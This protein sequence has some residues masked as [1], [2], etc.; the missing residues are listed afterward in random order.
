MA[1]FSAP[2]SANTSRVPCGSSSGSGIRGGGGGIDDRR[3]QIG[4]RFAGDFRVAVDDHVGEVREQTGGTVLA[5]GKLKQARRLVEEPRRHGAGQE[6]RVL[7]EVQQE[8]HVRLHAADAELLQRPVHPPGRVDEPDAVGRHLHEQR[9]VKR[10]DDRPAERAAV[11]PDAE[12]AG[13]AVRGEPA[14]I[15]GE[16]VGR[17]FR[18]H[19][20]LYRV[21]VGA[22]RGLVA[23]ADFRVAERRALRDE[24]LRLDEVVP[25]DD[26]RDRVFD[27]NPRVDLDEI[28]RAG[29]DIDEEL[30][31]AGVVDPGGA[32][33]FEG[34]FQNAVA[35]LRVEVRRRGEFDDLLVPPLNGTVAVEQVDEA[36]VPVAEQLHLDVLGPLD[37]LFEEHAAVAERTAGLAAGRF[38]RLGQFRRVADDPHAASAAAHRGLHDDRVR[39]LLR[40]RLGGG[41]VGDGVVAAGQHRDVGEP[42]ELTGR[43]LVAERFQH[44]RPGAD[45][46]DAGLGARPRELGVLGQEPVPGVDRVDA[47]VLREPDDAGDVEVRPDRL[48]GLADAVRLVGLEPVQGEPV[49]VGIDGDGADA[50]FVG[51]P[52]HTDGDLAPV[53]HEQL[54]DGLERGGHGSGALWGEGAGMIRNPRRADNLHGGQGDGPFEDAGGTSVPGR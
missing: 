21:P 26:L 50:E 30:D 39:Q 22:D 42:G 43:R 9:V 18:R 10:R 31:G 20:G 54:A 16:V 35:D 51:R 32:T 5:G 46:G 38:H 48:A 13:R 12:A 14:V 7:D 23:E 29:L 15:R 40:E 4:P 3:G 37:E 28:K 34:R 53:R 1:N 8:R 47:D 27:L 19:T 25:G 6:V 49:L 41:H 52:T 11:E 24:N 17:V 36:A 2:S 44:F 45:E 33:H